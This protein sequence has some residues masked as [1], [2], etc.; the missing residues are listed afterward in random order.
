[1]REVT[2]WDI[3][4]KYYGFP[5]CCV[6]KFH[7][8][9]HMSDGIARKLDG[10]GY[11]PCLA[12]NSKS[13]EE[14]IEAINKNRFDPKPF[15]YESE[16]KDASVTILNSPFFSEVEK[17][18]HIDHL[19]Y[20]QKSDE[21][22]ILFDNVGFYFNICTFFEARKMNRLLSKMESE[23]CKDPDEVFYKIVAIL[24]KKTEMLKFISRT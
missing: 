14:L 4:G 22:D 23:K 19:E 12:C 8:L 18:I 6:D 24:R 3:Y 9:E 13:E 5:T 1:M 11:I 21:D 17:L 2:S 16:H 15:P 10:T 20:M 7:T